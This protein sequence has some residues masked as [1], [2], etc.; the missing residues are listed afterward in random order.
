[1]IKR[2]IISVYQFDKETL[3]EKLFVK[4]THPEMWSR[5]NYPQ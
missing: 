3:L 4:E 2:V 1:M 5:L